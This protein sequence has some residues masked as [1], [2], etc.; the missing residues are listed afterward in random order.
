MARQARPA[1]NPRLTTEATS[2]KCRFDREIGEHWLSRYTC[3]GYSPLAISAAML[4]C[5]KGLSS[6]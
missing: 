6:G 1:S 4:A 3:F 5:T 2:V